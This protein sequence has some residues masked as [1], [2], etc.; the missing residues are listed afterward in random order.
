MGHRPGTADYLL[1]GGVPTDVA[2]VDGAARHTYADLRLAAGRTA[3]ALAALDLP[4]GSRVG[5]LG[6]NSVFWVAAYLAVL[7]LGH[8][9]VPLPDRA[10]AAA[11]RRAADLAGCAVVCA[12]R[13][14]L[15]AAGSELDGGPALLTDDVVTAGPDPCWP[16]GAPPDPAADAVLMFTSGTTSRPR[17]V[18]ITHRNLQA[19]TESVLAYLRLRPDDRILAVLPFHY[20]FGASLLHTH[21]R[22]GA[23]LVL[24][25]SLAFPRTVVDLL[26]REGCTGFAGVPS[27]FQLLLRAGTLA[28]RPLPSLRLVQAAGGAL[29]AVVVDELRAAQPQA[30][31]FVMYGQTEATA[32]LS[33]LPPDRLQDKRGS[34]GRGIP[35][36]ELTVRHPSGRPVVPGE[37]GEIYARGENVSPGY[38]DDP[39][40]TADKFT[41]HGLRTGDLAVVDEDGFVYVVDR[42]DDFIKSWGHRVSS[43]EVEAC[44][45]RLPDL[46]QAAAVGVPDAAA[47]EAIALFVTRH[48]SSAVT[49]ADVLAFCGRHLPR[50]MVPR[51]VTVVD[52]LPLTA[53]GKVAKAQLRAGALAS[54]PASGAAS[55]SAGVTAS[56]SDGVTAGVT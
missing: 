12:D 42:A 51:S 40:A 16:D 23:R 17:A 14:A 1:H 50:H 6:P 49:G 5:I 24:C 4:P 53:S 56:P 54:A 13:R 38:L 30:Q 45:L 29:P 33:Y 52:A 19:N 48:P 25:T 35:G 9:A 37:Q 8:V 39:G 20:C 31:L 22:A 27:T 34:I 28:T 36:V 43:Q 26:E 46:V 18:R 3:S 7:K 55:P 10:T 47:G 2:V 15:R 41:A 21:L 11:V 32:R 44:A